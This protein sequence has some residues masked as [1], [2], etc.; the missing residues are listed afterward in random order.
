MALY[1]QCQ[2]PHDI[3]TAI[4]YRYQETLP[5]EPQDIA[6]MHI[7]NNYASKWMTS[8]VG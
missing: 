3:C 1:T 6:R 5:K 2:P 4:Y 8:L 7:W